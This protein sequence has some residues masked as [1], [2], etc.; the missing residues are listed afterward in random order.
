MIITKITIN[1][2]FKERYLF[3]FEKKWYYKTYSTYIWNKDSDSALLTFVGV[4]GWK[5][6]PCLSNT[7]SSIPN[8]YLLDS[9]SI[10]IQRRQ[11]HPLQCSCLESPM[12][13]GAWWAAVHGVAKS[14]TRL[15]QLC[16]SSII[17]IHIYGNKKYF[18][19]LPKVPR[20]IKPPFL[21]TRNY[22][23]K[24]ARINSPPT[25]IVKNSVYSSKIHASSL[26]KKYKSG[27]NP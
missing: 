19:T 23:F 16:C 1:L 10:H 13:G 6:D 9:S 20:G 25:S 17:H 3:H 12:D 21:S 27:R 7:F 15:K 2:L 5:W 26:K 14:Q 24:R 18:Q 4:G 22:G 8:L 11:W